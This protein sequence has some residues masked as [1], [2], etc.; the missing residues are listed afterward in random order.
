MKL[1]KINAMKPKV[2]LS[3][4]NINELMM[5]FLLYIYVTISTPFV[6][7]D[8]KDYNISKSVYSSKK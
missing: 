1:N 6:V 5:V 7:I 2:F 3:N 4:I 8:N